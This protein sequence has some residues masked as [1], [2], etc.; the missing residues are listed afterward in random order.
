MKKL[1]V[2]L[3]LLSLTTFGFGCNDKDKAKKTDDKKTEQPADDKKADDKKA[4][5]K[6]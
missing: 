1:T 5:D 3:T 2:F 6:E 4:D